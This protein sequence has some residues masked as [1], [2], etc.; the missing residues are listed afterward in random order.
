MHHFL[1][2]EELMKRSVAVSPNARNIRVTGRL[3]FMEYC[4][5]I[6]NF[7]STQNR[8]VTTDLSEVN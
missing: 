3:L 7:Q 1:A 8:N 5:V 2:L 4:T 6:S